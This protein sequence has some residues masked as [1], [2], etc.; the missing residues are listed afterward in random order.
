[1]SQVTNSF[2]I[3]FT[4][5]FQPNSTWSF[6]IHNVFRESIDV[7]LA[8]D[9]D[10]IF[11]A[12]KIVLNPVCPFLRNIYQKTSSWPVSLNSSVGSL[13]KHQD[14]SSKTVVS[15]FTTLAL[16]SVSVNSSTCA[17]VFIVQVVTY[18]CMW[19]LPKT[20]TTTRPLRSVWI[21][22]QVILSKYSKSI[23]TKDASSNVHTSMV[24][25]SIIILLKLSFQVRY[26]LLK[27]LIPR[28]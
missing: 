8:G 12:H 20:S 9:D 27:S 1:M 11:G 15:S 13:S 3:L 2:S 10:R 4:I 22:F 17:F 18:T 24:W 5:S 26:L 21:L 19:S 16:S 7:T 6:C 25:A 23:K 14:F 28:D